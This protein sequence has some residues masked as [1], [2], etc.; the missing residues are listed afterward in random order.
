MEFRNACFV[1]PSLGPGRSDCH[2]SSQGKL[3]PGVSGRWP[4]SSPRPHGASLGARWRRAGRGLDRSR[5]LVFDSNS[6]CS[7]VD[8][9]SSVSEPQLV[10]GT[11][12]LTATVSGVEGLRV[13]SR[14]SA[15]ALK[16]TK[17][18]PPF[19]QIR[20]SASG[21]TESF[22]ARTMFP[23][24]DR[25]HCLSDWYWDPGTGDGSAR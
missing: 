12:Q 5:N 16:G 23:S 2:R 10:A 17:R 11:D 13:T 24:L 6:A 9:G 18:L 4:A 8:R 21:R 15:F 1:T 19:E 3:C 7:F 14:T 20:T 25:T 22:A